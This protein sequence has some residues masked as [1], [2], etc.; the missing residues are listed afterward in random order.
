LGQLTAPF[1]EFMDP[2]A[3][4]LLCMV[5]YFSGVVQSPITAFVILVEMTDARFMTLPLALASM[6]AFEASRL[7]CP[8][9]LYEGLA[10]NFMSRLRPSENKDP[11]PT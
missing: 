8:T 6:L 7:V 2:Q 1:L 11:P 9:S 3:V 10:E 5:S 4:I